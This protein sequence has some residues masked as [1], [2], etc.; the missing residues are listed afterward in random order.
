MRYD[1]LKLCEL[2]QHNYALRR[3]SP[4]QRCSPILAVHLP[5]NFLLSTR[6]HGVWIH[7]VPGSR[8]QGRGHQEGGFQWQKKDEKESIFPGRHARGCGHSL[9]GEKSLLGTSLSTESICFPI[10]HPKFVYLSFLYDDNDDDEGDDIPP[11]SL[12][13]LFCVV[14]TV[15]WKM[16]FLL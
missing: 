9:S 14:H 7:P 6:H 8:T 12:Y 1:L 2:L 16:G 4:Q 13:S 15:L 10:F 3:C 11:P 5:L